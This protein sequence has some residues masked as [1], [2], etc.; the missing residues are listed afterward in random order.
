MI[1]EIC[2]NSLPS[3]LAA[4]AGGADRIELCDN[5]AE[6][7]TT[8]SYATILTSRE[9]LTIQIYPI[10]RPRGGDFLYND[11]EFDLMRKDIELCKQ[12]GCDGVVIGLL[13]MD[14]SIDK[15]R[16]K[17][18]VELAWP[19][20]V[21]FH[22]AFDRCADPFHALEDIIACGC[23]RILTSGQAP[24]APEGADLIAQLVDRA[25][26]RMIIMPGSGVRENNIAALVRKTKATEYHSTAKTTIGSKM[27]FKNKLVLDSEV[28][29]LN[30][31]IT[32]V[33]IVRKL[34]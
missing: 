1:L 17:L 20:G 10:I 8:P 30:I 11:D 25:A 2:A 29:E 23:E 13:N 26:G 6:G 14:G 32:D 27:Q 21:T 9:M 4:Q 16:T 31:E 3:A 24:T 28:K 34:K 33:D 7:G 5:M 22:R 12:V 19:L 18:L 15:K